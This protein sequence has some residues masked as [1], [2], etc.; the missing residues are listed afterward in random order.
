ML[1]Q[2]SNNSC[3]DILINIG[4]LIGYVQEIKGQLF[5]TSR[6]ELKSVVDKYTA[7]IPP[8]LSSQF[9]DRVKKADAVESYRKRQK[10]ETT[11]LY[12]AGTT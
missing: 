6:V 10:R 2:Y 5:N 8:S 9:R 1:K 3:I 11:Q 7:K 12:P 4:A